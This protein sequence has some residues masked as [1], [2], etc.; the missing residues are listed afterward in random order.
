MS[1]NN[2]MEAAEILSLEEQEILLEVLHK[3]Y[4]EHQRE[5]LSIDIQKANK[6]FK[7]GKCK[8]LTPSNIMK[9]ILI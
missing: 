2:V 9:E 8:V 6:D 1:L 7:S 4:I 3:R 5:M